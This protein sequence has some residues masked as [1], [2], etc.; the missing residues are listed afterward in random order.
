LE[1]KE[2]NKISV[3][4]PLKHTAPQIYKIARETLKRIYVDRK[5]DFLR[6]E[7]ESVGN[8]DIEGK[9]IEAARYVVHFVLYERDNILLF[10][11]KNS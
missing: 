2:V 11:Q 4:I 5:F 6:A 9:T 7:F 1:R 8:F 3:T 10:P